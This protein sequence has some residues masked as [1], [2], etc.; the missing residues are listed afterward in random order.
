MDCGDDALS[1]FSLGETVLGK[2]RPIQKFLLVIAVISYLAAVGC[3]VAAAYLGVGSGDPN[4]ASLMA[5]VVFFIGVGVVLH[6][7][8]SGHL[9]D[10]KVK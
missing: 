7:M 9:P 3:G 1:L 6:V 2:R 8:G 5:S 4:V 10:L